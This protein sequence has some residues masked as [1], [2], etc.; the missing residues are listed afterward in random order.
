[1]ISYRNV[2]ITDGFWANRQKINRETTVN[3]V[4]D[5]FDDTGRIT[6]FNVNW[7]EGEPNQPHFYWDSDVAKWMEGAAAI[8]SKDN[9]PE[10]E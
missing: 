8:L 6:A 9:I 10:L 4:Y 2:N 7:K 5:R 3:A 1:M